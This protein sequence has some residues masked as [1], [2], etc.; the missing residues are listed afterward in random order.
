MTMYDGRSEA[1]REIEQ[2][3]MLQDL[4]VSESTLVHIK[5]QTEADSHLQ[6]L[7]Q[8]IKEGWPSTL[9]EVP[10]A[11]R[12]YHPFRD[13]LTVQNGVILKGERLIVPAGM[14]ADMKVKLHHNHSGIQATLRRAREICYWPGMNKDIEEVI[15]K[16]NI[17]AQYQA[18]NQKEPLMSSPVPTR[19]WESIATDLF[20]LRSKDYLV[21][22]D[23][24]SNFIEVDRLYSKTSAEVIHKLKAHMARYGIPERVVSDNGPQYSSS[25][26]QDFAAKYEFEHVTSSPR[27][28]QSNGKAESAVK[29][30]KRLMEKALDAKSDPYLAI[31]EHRNTPSDGMTTSPAQR[32]LGRRTR[33]TIPAS[34][35]LLEPTCWRSAEQELQQAKTKQAY[36][37]NKGSKQLPALEVGDAVRMLP[38]KGR[39]TGRKGKVQAIVSPR[40]YI[41]R[42]D[43]GGNYRRNRRHLR[44]TLES[45]EKEADIE[46]PMKEQN[47]ADLPTTPAFEEPVSQ[48]RTSTRQ[49]RR[50]AYLEDYVTET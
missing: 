17:C 10:Q 25:E 26:F 49:R 44:K 37:Y 6:A 35:T 14:R 11:L 4:A 40:S 34:R 31:L 16:C 20:E 18:A 42:A 33:T 27:Y 38:E 8:I 50:P 15:A 24:Y 41:V 28:P 19:P 9:S 30:A 39:K 48:Q 2:V 47:P 12:V 22:V 43:S 45:D 32:L 13:E 5:E 3:D 7:V 46:L 29:T 21:T 36:Y 23:Y 1:E